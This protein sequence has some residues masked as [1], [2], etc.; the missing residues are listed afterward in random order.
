M[1][2]LNDIADKLE[3]IDVN[4]TL[5][6]VLEDNSEFL[7][8]E[9]IESLD[10]GKYPQ[11]GDF[12][13]PPY[14]PVTVKIKEEK[15]QQ[16]DFVNLEDTGEFKADMLANVGSDFVEIDS[17]DSKSGKLKE[18]Y[19]DQIFGIGDFTKRQIQEINIKKLQ[20]QL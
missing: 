5:A 20:S 8:E 1:K 17:T 14:S 7:V 11:S 6:G 4:K 2:V 13:E 10:E 18:K 16:T 15:G 9:N 3:R 12:I 19:G